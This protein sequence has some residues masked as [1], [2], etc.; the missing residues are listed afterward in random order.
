[1]KIVVN[2]I[3]AIAISNRPPKG[4]KIRLVLSLVVSG[5]R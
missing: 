4:F 5:E 1:M 2:F 3:K